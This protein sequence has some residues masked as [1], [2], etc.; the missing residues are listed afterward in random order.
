M[1]GELA[2]SAWAK[3]SIFC[4]QTLVHLFSG[5]KL[6]FIPLSPCPLHPPPPQFLGFW[7]KVHCQ[8][9]WVSSLQT[10]DHGTSRPPWLHQS[11]P[12]LNPLA[13]SI[14]SLFS[15]RTQWIHQ[16]LYIRMPLTIFL[17]LGECAQLSVAVSWLDVHLW[18]TESSSVSKVHLVRQRQFSIPTFTISNS[19]INIIILWEIT[20]V[21]LA[22]RLRKSTSGEQI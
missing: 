21:F 15:W 13:S 7:I 17:V 8:C 11:I 5:F 2:V 18:V 14:S 3:T 16:S 22:N 4:S 20:S 10:A 19:Q 6:R 9:F 12:V 1:E